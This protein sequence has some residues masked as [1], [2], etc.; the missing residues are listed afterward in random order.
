MLWALA[1]D[2]YTDIDNYMQNIRKKYPRPKEQGVQRFRNLAGMLDCLT[3]P[4]IFLS[5][6]INLYLIIMY[7]MHTTTFRVSITRSINSCQ[8]S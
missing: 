1:N 2:V 6:F 5:T 3:Q 8:V 4:I 7:M